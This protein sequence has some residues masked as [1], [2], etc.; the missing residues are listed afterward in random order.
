MTRW[1]HSPSLRRYKSLPNGPLSYPAKRVHVPI[2][3][4]SP[5]SCFYLQ[6]LFELANA[7]LQCLHLLFFCQFPRLLIVQCLE[8]LNLSLQVQYTSMEAPYFAL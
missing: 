2:M 3:Y 6:F 7:C 4:L 1:Q 5:L 8:V